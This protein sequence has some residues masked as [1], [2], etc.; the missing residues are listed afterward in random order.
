MR[1]GSW[2][3]GLFA[4][5]LLVFLSGSCAPPLSELFVGAATDLSAPD[6]LNR[7]VLSAR[8][9][10]VEVVHNEWDISGLPGTPYQLPGSFNIYTNDGSEPRVEIV[11][12]GYTGEQEIVRR[13]ALLTLVRGERKFLRMALVNRCM[14]NLDC[15]AGRTC[16]EGRCVPAEINA[17]LL[18]AYQAG[19]EEAMSCDSGTVLINTSTKQP[20]PM[21]GSGSCGEGE[22]CGEGTCVRQEPSC[23]DGVRNGDETDVDCGGSCAG[24]GGGKQCG[25]SGDCAAGT[26]TGGV[27]STAGQ[28]ICGDGNTDRNTGEQCDDS[29]TVTETGCPYGTPTCTACN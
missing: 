24:C 26:C 10:G 2:F 13:R 25:V 7:V 20:M 21:T 1:R 23:Q 29:N 16:V 28:A 3:T 4:M 14:N 19:M 8:R 18:P 5:V 17:R 11:L 9:E 22:R 6:V 27:C 15:P 12:S